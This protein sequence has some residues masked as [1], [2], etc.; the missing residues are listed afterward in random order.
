M[1]DNWYTDIGGK[2]KNLAKWTFIVEA[3]VAIIT[4][5]F[6]LIDWGFEDGWWALFVILFGPIVAYVSS[7]LL[8]AFGQL[9]ENT[10]DITNQNAV[11]NRNVKI[12]AQPIIDEVEKKRKAEDDAKRKSKE[13]A[14]REAEEKTEHHTEGKKEWGA[15]ANFSVTEKGTIICAQCKF[16]Q[17]GNR[18][19]CWHC[20][21][22]FKNE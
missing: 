20:G 8:Y 15:I 11:I 3:I 21:A 9:V 2:I 17:P 13:D 19:C 1:L 12:I 6:F 7:W 10:Y 4:G 5:L 22:K 18:S 14:K 16:E